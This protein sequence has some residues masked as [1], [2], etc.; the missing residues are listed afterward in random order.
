MLLNTPVAD[1]ASARGCAA[2]PGHEQEFDESIA[3]S[4]DYAR[5][6]GCARPTP[7]SSP[8]PACAGSSRA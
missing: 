7:T 4:L 1:G 2:L 3:R 8:S 6:T 5:A